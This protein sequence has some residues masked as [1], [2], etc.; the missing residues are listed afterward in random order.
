MTS[1]VHSVYLLYWYQST[2]TDAEDAAGLV[3]GASDDSLGSLTD[4]YQDSGQGSWHRGAAAGDFKGTPT[5]LAL[6]VHE[7]KY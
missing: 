2:N 4:E 5:L 3:R 6:M 7:N 1:E